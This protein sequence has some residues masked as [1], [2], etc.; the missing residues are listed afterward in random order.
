M[1]GDDEMKAQFQ[2]YK[3][4]QAEFQVNHQQLEA[5][6]K[7][8]LVYFSSLSHILR[9]PEKLKRKSINLNKKRNNSTPKSTLS[10]PDT[11]PNPNSKLSSKPPI[12]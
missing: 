6:Q 8:A 7:E 5:A 3:D 2:E 9:T 12:S 11:V 4:R 1:L 10:K